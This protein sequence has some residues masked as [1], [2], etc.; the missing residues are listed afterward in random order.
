MTN[1]YNT[2]LRH[3]LLLSIIICIVSCIMIVI[4]II[5]ILN[6]D[7]RLSMVIIPISG[8]TAFISFANSS[9]IIYQ[10]QTSIL[11]EI[12][13]VNILV[14]RRAKRQTLDIINKM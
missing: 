12:F 11:E 14:E 9:D 10:T 5:L 8:L 1:L 2:L 4:G 6:Y 3:E 7:N 13:G